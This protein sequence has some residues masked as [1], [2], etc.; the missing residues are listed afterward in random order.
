[1]TPSPRPLDDS[2]MVQWA[3][4]YAS[5]G[6][7]VMPLHQPL[8]DNIGA[9]CGCTC[10]AWKRQ[11][12]DPEYVCPT[13]GKH[14]IHSAWED[15]ATTDAD[16]IRR[17][18]HAWPSANIGLAVG[19]SGLLTL[20]LDAYKDN[21]AGADLLT[22]AEEETIT[23]LSGGGG[24][25]L[26][27]AMPEGKAWGNHRGELPAGIDVRG[28]GGMQVIA[29][30]M[31]P[32]GTRYAWELDYGPDEISALPVPEHLA[33]ILDDA[34]AKAKPSKAIHFDQVTTDR[35]DLA[36]WK[37]AGAIVD[38]IN[39]TPAKGGRSEHDMRV[40]V[41]LCYAGL[42][43]DQILAIFQHFPI[44]TGKYAEGGA[45]YLA[46]TIGNARTYVEAHPPDTS[47]VV[48]PEE[49]RAE[50]AALRDWLHSFAG[51]EALRDRGIVRVDTYR[52][53]MDA[54][55]NYAHVHGVRTLRPGL[56]K[57]G[58]AYNASTHTVRNHL[59]KLSELELIEV[60]WEARPLAIKLAPAPNFTPSHSR[61]VDQGVKLGAG[62]QFYIDN[63]PDDAFLYSHAAYKRR[64]QR[65][66]LDDGIAPFGPTGLAVAA[67]LY[68][69]GPLTRSEIREYT[70]SGKYAIKKVT[71]RMAE[72]GVLLASEGDR[73]VVTYDLPCDYAQRLNAERPDLQTDGTLD[74]RKRQNAIHALA[75]AKA[76][77]D[78]SPRRL[79]KLETK[80]DR[81]EGDGAAR[82]VT[83]WKPRRRAQMDPAERSAWLTHLQQV[84]QDLQ[85]ASAD[86]KAFYMSCAGYD[87]KEIALVCSGRIR[88]M[89]VTDGLP[90][91]VIQRVRVR[92]EDRKVRSQAEMMAFRAELDALQMA[93]D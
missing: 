8:F 6:W 39:A 89:K 69:H 53:C 70:G 93:A 78:T 77:P 52:K 66:G 84:E 26:L 87:E 49:V 25:H 64:R 4:W 56:G 65:A 44:G 51:A 54:L 12:R 45:R 67:A 57:L 27:Y 61:G 36:A 18:W 72:V 88:Y 83:R 33:A 32:S 74:R 23:Q 17:W 50:V 82:W 16:Q 48:D 76:D 63:R 38:A 13:P 92:K 15:K 68:E 30:S 24:A 20:D 55:C 86:D 79:A 1:M 58:E 73:G 71:R 85:D 19:K 80:V 43:D 21:F 46:R 47:G 10:E 91:D 2:S 35:P 22:R 37:L 5:M 75:W 3:L 31:H 7:H 11:N 42:T 60:D 81:L 90:V 29:P 14:P 62:Q 9:V 34:A 41:A 40:V 59:R 28:V